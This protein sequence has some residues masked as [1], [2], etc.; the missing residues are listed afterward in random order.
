MFKLYLSKLNIRCQKLWQWGH[1]GYVHYNDNEWYES[2][3]VGHDP[4]ERFMKYLTKDAKLAAQNYTNHSIRATVIGTLDSK[5]FEA[6]HI[7][8]IS[9][10]KNEST[11]KTYAK[12]C[13]EKKKS[14]MYEALN[15]TLIPP[16]KEK[17]SIYSNKTK[18]KWG[19]TNHKC[20]RSWEINEY[21]EQ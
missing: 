6:H 20:P 1:Q 8:A 14:E 3:P 19:I 16:K 2:R 10:H 12:K 17:T 9:S 15:E 4:I 21:W 18:W 7:T 13:P 11:I 5:G